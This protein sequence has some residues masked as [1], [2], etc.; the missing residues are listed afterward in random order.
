MKGGILL[1][2][3]GRKLFLSLELVNKL[4]EEDAGKEALIE[5]LPDVFKQ[6]H[7]V[8]MFEYA[9]TPDIIA[10]KYIRFY[11]D[12][13]V[14]GIVDLTNPFSFNILDFYLIPSN[15]TIYDEE[16]GETVSRIDF[17][18]KGILIHKGY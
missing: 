14:F 2:H 16:E 17:E 1:D 7:E 15:E 11:T 18:R 9:N 3:L 8:Y 6:A 10:G 5:Y 13:A 4:I 12:S